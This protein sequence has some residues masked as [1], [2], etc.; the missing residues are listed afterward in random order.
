MRKLN[1][2]RQ[3]HKTVV[4]SATTRPHIASPRTPLGR[5]GNEVA[6]TKL[7]PDS[8]SRLLASL[9]PPIRLDAKALTPLHHQFDEFRR[10]PKSSVLQSRKASAGQETMSCGLLPGPFSRLVPSLRPSTNSELRRR[11]AQLPAFVA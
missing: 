1:R 7:R 9:H 2:A 3:C 11:T 5:D 4:E 6:R 8:G 10:C